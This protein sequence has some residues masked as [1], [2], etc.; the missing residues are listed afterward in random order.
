[1]FDDFPKLIELDE[2]TKY[3]EPTIQ[4][5]RPHE[6]NR[7]G[8]V[9]AASEALD[10]IK[11]V[12]PRPGQTIIL[13]LAM[14]AGEF[15][16]CNR[17][18]DAWSERP[19]IVGPTKITEDDVLP[20]HYQ[21]FENANVFKHHINKD[22]E[23]RVGDVIKAFYNWPMHRVELLLSLL[24]DRAEDIVNRIENGEFPAVSMGCRV[25]H[26]V[27]AICGHPARNRSEYCD[28]AKY[29][30]GELLPNGKR[31]FVWNPSPRFFDISMVR[32]PADRLGFMMKKVA[33][34]IPEIR[35][36]AELGE[37]VERLSRKVASLRKMSLMHK[38]LTGHA[39][40][41]NDGDSAFMSQVAKP[42]AQKTPPLDDAAIRS[43]LAANPAAVLAT[44]SSMGILL[45]TPEFIKF[46]VWK[47][48]PA[49]DIP[50]RV[51]D[52]AVAAQTRIFEAL[53]EN[54]EILDEADDTGLMRNMPTDKKLAAAL[55]SWAEKRSLDETPLLGRLLAVP[56]HTPKHAEV[57]QRLTPAQH[58]KLKKL[59]GV[60]ALLAATY[61][62][63]A[64]QKPTK[65]AVKLAMDV[66]HYPASKH[67][68]MPP[69]TGNTF[70]EL[71]DAIG[72]S[73]CL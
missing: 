20:K 23:K 49:L 36:S 5:V 58:Y 61:T 67:T 18:G 4:I 55:G 25:K 33:D 11:H 2:L 56:T 14:T 50:P 40:A 46:F 54:P 22:P 15:Y 71:A 51:L 42:A 12:E 69:L 38:L 31:V 41:A 17:N 63:N 44:L 9:K 34:Y 16:G 60:G 21:T 27:C 47:M 10:Y 65:I 70:D 52:R 24:H 1:M 19:L 6:Y 66:G 29:Q 73:I 53:S 48:D 37:H 35:S 59:A 28:H 45:T 30:L 57:S 26:D 68:R 32:R 13:V 3:D 7:L 39:V 62:L 72:E 8:H 64:A 43:M